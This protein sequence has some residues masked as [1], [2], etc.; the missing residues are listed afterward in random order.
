MQGLER[1][2]DESFVC[3]A[4]HAARR[5]QA[6]SSMPDAAMHALMHAALPV[7]LHATRAG[8]IIGH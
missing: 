3:H 2:Y 8:V 7:D 5:Q 6:S 4:M 1:S